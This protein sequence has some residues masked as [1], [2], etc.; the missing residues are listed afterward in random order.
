MREV[1]IAK[2]A[3]CPTFRDSLTTHLFEAG[4]HGTTQELPGHKDVS[5]MMVYAHVLNRVPAGVCSQIGSL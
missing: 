4:N 2:R 3:N 1:G 5:T